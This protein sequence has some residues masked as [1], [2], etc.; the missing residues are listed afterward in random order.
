MSHRQSWRSCL[1][2]SWWS[3]CS[4]WW[5]GGVRTPHH[6]SAS[7]L[8]SP[9]LFWSVLTRPHCIP[10]RSWAQGSCG[11]VHSF[12]GISSWENDN[13]R[14]GHPLGIPW[15]SCVAIPFLSVVPLTCATS[16]VM[17]PAWCLP[18]GLCRSRGGT[19]PMLEPLLP[20]WRATDSQTSRIQNDVSCFICSMASLS[21]CP[22]D[23]LVNLPPWFRSA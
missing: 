3:L 1:T 22:I 14:I 23:Q 9:T 13:D 15:P 8:S 10:I 18:L 7:G 5:S 2:L 16:A 12:L 20:F 4:R 11:N 19:P 6:M 17:G 21:P